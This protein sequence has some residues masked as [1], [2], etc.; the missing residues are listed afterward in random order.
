MCLYLVSE[1]HARCEDFFIKSLVEGVEADSMRKSRKQ[2]HLKY[3]AKPIYYRKKINL[4]FAGL[5]SVLM[6]KNCGHGFE[7]A[8]LGHSFSTCGPP[9]R[10]IA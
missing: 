4:L 1:L 5:G 2:S 3:V 10:Q 6:V 8:A 7:I 9:S